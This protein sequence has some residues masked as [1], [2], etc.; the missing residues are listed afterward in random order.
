[1][2][3]FQIA[4]FDPCSADPDAWAAFHAHRCAI[5]AELHP[6]DPV[7]GDDECADEM[8]RANPLS[9]CR[10]WLATD[11]ADAVGFAVAWF[12]RAGAP[13]AA[14]HA[15]FLK[16]D[17][18]VLA[19]ARRSGIGTLLLRQ[20]HTLMHETGK[21]VLTL[22]GETDPG[23]A[24]LTHAG[25]AP[26]LSLVESRTLLAHLDWPRLRTWEDIAGSLGLAWECYA[27]RVPRETLAALLPAVNKL[28]SDIP[29]GTLD[30]APVRLE[31]EFY[32][33]RYACMA[34]TGGMHHL[35][36]LRAPDGAVVAM[37][38]AAWDAR[39]PKAVSQIFTAIARPWRGHGLAR[40]VKAAILRQIRSANP[41]AQEVRTFNAEC[42]APIL[43]L[44]RRLGFIKHG[45]CVYYQITRAELDAKLGN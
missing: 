23:H 40:A 36:L 33:R 20:V 8:R 37:S 17:G 43:A 7:M 42:N 30:A 22:Y 15:R 32:D 13:N 31:M 34:R 25:A 16:C 35:V 18:S 19:S 9:E 39:C 11:G 3:R 24:F 6:D 29:L 45:R 44:N 27:G 4:P 28:V 26:K 14:D 5:A 10:R 41:D 38:E 1:M 21:S 12:R 2:P